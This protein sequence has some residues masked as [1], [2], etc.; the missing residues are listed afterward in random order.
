MAAHDGFGLVNDAP[1]E[2]KK[3]ARC[4]PLIAG[5]GNLNLEAVLRPCRVPQKNMR[6]ITRTDNIYTQ[7]KQPPKRGPS[8]Q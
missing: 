3:G 1:A 2:N 5:L 4:Q 6:D 8:L 7:I